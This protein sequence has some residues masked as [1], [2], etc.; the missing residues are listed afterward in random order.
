MV[1]S[2]SY[3]LAVEDL[4]TWNTLTT[5]LRPRAYHPDYPSEK[6]PSDIGKNTKKAE[7]EKG[8]ERGSI[9]GRWELLHRR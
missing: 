2:C 5:D 3:L 8:R 1:I 7:N 9:Y 6:H 4:M